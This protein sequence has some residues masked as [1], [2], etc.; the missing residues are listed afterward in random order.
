[1][2]VSLVSEEKNGTRMLRECVQIWLL[3]SLVSVEIDDRK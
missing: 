1:M 3:T 2:N